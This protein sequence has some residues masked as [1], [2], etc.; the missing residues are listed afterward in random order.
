HLVPCHRIGEEAQPVARVL[1]VLA[2]RKPRDELLERRVRVAHRL[3][4]ALRRIELVDVAQD[5][6][7]LAEVDEA[8]EVERVVDVG[9]VRIRA[10][11]AVARGGRRLGLAQPVVRVRALEDRLLRETPVRE[12]ALDLV[13][14]ACSACKIAVGE[15]LVRLLVQALGRPAGRL[16]L[17]HVRQQAASAREQRAQRDDRES[18]K[19]IEEQRSGHRRHRSDNVTAANYTPPPMREPAA[20][21]SADDVVVPPEMAGLRLD[22]ALARLLPQHS[23]NRIQGWIAA[24]DVTVDG[25]VRAPRHR[26]AGGERL[27]IAAPPVEPDT[28]HAGE[29]IALAIVYEDDA[30]IV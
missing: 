14:E 6:L 27:R 13:E 24:G 11:E 10:D 3:R 19:T 9:M 29:A 21:A 1:A 28:T 30:I 5:P 18:A 15:R 26:L 20:E 17:A 25:A 16:V 8:L 22:L 12:A 2:V 23:R 4:V 7:V